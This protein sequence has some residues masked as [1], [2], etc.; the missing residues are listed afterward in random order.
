MARSRSKSTSRA[1]DFL[2][3]D[4]Y[5]AWNALLMLHRSVLADLDAALRSAHGITV[6]EFD[7]LITLF[8]APG[9]R[10]GMGALADRAMLSPAGVTHL[11]TRL[12]R[13]GLVRREPDP[14]DGRKSFTEL[15]DQGDDVLRE[16]RGTHNA[17]LRR[18]LLAATT[19]AERKALRAVW[20]RLSAPAPG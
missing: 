19:A 8:N 6:T 12:E 20:R 3:P 7:V 15:T 11:V 17:V 10:L 2:E 5:E 1:H 4:E 18:T 9:R 16:G 13:D 14:D